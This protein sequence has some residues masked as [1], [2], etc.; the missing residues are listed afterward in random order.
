MTAAAGPIRKPWERYRDNFSRHLIGVSRYLQTRMMH[1][2]QA[3][4]GH[5]DLRLGF[6]P[7]I[8]LV[9][10]EGLRLS[11]LAATLHISRQACNQAV[12]QIEA[13][14][15]I[16]RVSDPSDGRAR[17]LAL[18]ARGRQLRADG[19]RV[20]RDLDRQFGQIAGADDV[21]RAARTLG[22][23]YGELSLGM[24]ALGRA[25]VAYGGLGGLLPRSADYIAQRLM[26]LTAARGHPGLKLSFAQV[27]TLM[28]PGGGRIQQMAALNDVSK[29]AISAIATELQQLGYLRREADPSDARQLRL[30]F[31]P[32]GE[33]LIADS[34][35][36]VEELEGEFAALVGAPAMR[37]LAATLRTLYQGLQ[38]EQDVFA[39][40]E[41]D[42]HRL[43]AQLRQRLGE[44][45]SQALGR[46]LLQPA[47]HSEVA[48][49]VE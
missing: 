14:G 9:G 34:V 4:C 40:G 45:S 43:A 22:R 37:Q 25:Q 42:I 21:A 15:Y 6:A 28:G 33:Q 11:E 19:V 3:Q 23:I 18:T 30:L 10:D 35:A 26:Q 44:E 8:T 38:L 39:D 49:H 24:G 31:T 36:S 5:R 12:N 27:L 16:G 1:T 17:L 48:N 47:T 32:R 7:Y 29:Q 20:V 41:E 13:A 46:L 2:L